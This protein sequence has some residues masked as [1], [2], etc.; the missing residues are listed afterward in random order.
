MS[1]P[2]V[3]NASYLGAN[4]SSALEALYGCGRP[5][6]ETHNQATSGTYLP[7]RPGIEAP[8]PSAR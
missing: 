6:I 1:A 2:L 7:L 5:A 4:L 3:T 8:C